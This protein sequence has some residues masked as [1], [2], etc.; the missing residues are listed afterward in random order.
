MHG[1]FFMPVQEKERLFHTELV[2]YGVEYRI[3]GKVA[4]ILAL[5]K[6]DELLTQQERQLVQKACQKWLTQHKRKKRIDSMIKTLGY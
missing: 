3:A 4:R 5:G 6:S 2:K 1:N